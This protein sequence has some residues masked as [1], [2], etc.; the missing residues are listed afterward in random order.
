VQEDM[1]C[2]GSEGL[3]DRDASKLVALNFSNAC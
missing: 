1:L 2:P 3:S